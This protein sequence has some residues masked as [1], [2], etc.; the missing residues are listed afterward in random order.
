MTARAYRTHR[1][2]IF[3]NGPEAEQYLHGQISQNVDDM[4][5]GDA[6]WSF[7]LE[8]RGN[9]EGFFRILRVAKDS[10]RLDT[11]YGFG[12]TLEESLSRFKLRSKVEFTLSAEEMISVVGNQSELNVEGFTQPLP[13]GWNDGLCIDLLGG[14]SAIDLEECSE[15]DFQRLVMT[16]GLPRLGEEFKVGGIPNESGVL[17][18][19]VSFDKGC[20]RG[21]EL[22]ERIDARSGGRR[23][24]RRVRA[25]SKLEKS[26]ALF[27]GEKKVGEVLTV[28]NE[29]PYI[30]F[31]LLGTDV[32]PVLTESGERIEVFALDQLIA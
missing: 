6:R 11:E 8:P 18:L 9:I 29:A 25:E 4:A 1:D 16:H 3:A 28:T 14:D 31:A 17:A 13:S 21:Q 19:A 22:V 27:G 32:A 30:G 23:I 10:Y 7:L 2:V 24:I 5:E 15:N 26:Q 12:Q 20:Y